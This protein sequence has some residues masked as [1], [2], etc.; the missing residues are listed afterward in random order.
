MLKLLMISILRYLKD[1]KLWEFWYLPVLRNAG[2]ISSTVIAYNPNKGTS[3]L[4][5]KYHEN[6]STAR[7]Q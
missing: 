5:T 2:F 6:L 3:D 1:P 7:C 4:L